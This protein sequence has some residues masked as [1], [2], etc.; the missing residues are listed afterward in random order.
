MFKQVKKKAGAKALGEMASPG[1]RRPGRLR[2]RVERRSRKAQV[3]QS[4]SG[5][6]ILLQTQFKRPGKNRSG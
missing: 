3:T 4:N 5:L 6:W 2:C 1:E